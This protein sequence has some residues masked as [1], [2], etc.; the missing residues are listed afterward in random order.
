MHELV[1][2]AV[3]S[4]IDKTPAEH[5]AAIALMKHLIAEQILRPA[6]LVQGFERTRK[7]LTLSNLIALALSLTR[8]ASILQ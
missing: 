3:V 8:K 2:Q 4:S 5:E 6:Q 7:R 1:K